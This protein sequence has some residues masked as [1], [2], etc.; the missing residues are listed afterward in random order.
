V[1]TDLQHPPETPDTLVFLEKVIITQI[2]YHPAAGRPECS[3]SLKSPGLYNLEK[4]T[5]EQPCLPGL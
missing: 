2:E 1:I 5:T 3:D 4:M